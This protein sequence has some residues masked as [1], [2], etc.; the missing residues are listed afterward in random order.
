VPWVPWAKENEEKSGRFKK[1]NAQWG[2]SSIFWNAPQ[3]AEEKN[4]LCNIP[5]NC[6]QKKSSKSLC[7]YPNFTFKIRF[8]NL[9]NLRI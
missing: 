9:K 4:T 7:L 3:I 6:H 8:K 1:C 2:G 5:L